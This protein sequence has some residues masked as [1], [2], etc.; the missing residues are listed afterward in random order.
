MLKPSTTFICDPNQLKY[1]RCHFLRMASL[2]CDSYQVTWRGPCM[3]S[4]RGR[5]RA[6]DDVKIPK[7]TIPHGCPQ[8]LESWPTAS[9]S[10]LLSDASCSGQWDGEVQICVCGLW[11]H[12]WGLWGEAAVLYCTVHEAQVCLRSALGQHHLWMALWSWKWKLDLLP[13]WAKL[14]KKSFATWLTLQ[15]LIHYYYFYFNR[16]S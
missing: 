14:F 6:L 15:I 1:W 13:S 5:T 4:A 10:L 16:R 9:S 3:E 2:K 7:K 8:Q 11:G 12:K